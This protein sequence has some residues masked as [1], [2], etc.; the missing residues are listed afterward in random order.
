MSAPRRPAS[1][2]GAAP[3]ALVSALRAAACVCFDVDSTVITTEGID[4]L[5]AFAGKRDAVAAMTAAAMGGKVPFHEA[6]EARLRVIA[7]TQ[8]LLAGFLAAHPHQ[9]TPRMAEVVAALRSEPP[10]CRV[11]AALG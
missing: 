5:A 10:L 1:T 9:L 11:W 8:A 6:L 4:E 7:P 2:A 3:Q